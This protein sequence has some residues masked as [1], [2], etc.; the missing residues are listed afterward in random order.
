MLPVA[1]SSYTSSHGSMSC[2]MFPCRE[3]ASISPQDGRTFLHILLFPEPI[4]IAASVHNWEGGFS[5]LSFP[6]LF[7]LSFLSSSAFVFVLAKRIHRA[8]AAL[9]Q[10]KVL[11]GSRPLINLIDSSVW[12]STGF[13]SLYL[14]APLCLSEGASHLSI[15]ARLSQI[16]FVDQIKPFLV[17]CFRTYSSIQLISLVTSS[18]YRVIM[19]LNNRL[20]FR[21]GFIGMQVTFTHPYR[22]TWRLE[23]KLNTENIRG[24][25]YGMGGTDPIW[26]TTPREARTVYRCSKVDGDPRVTE[27]EAVMKVRMQ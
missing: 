15:L 7:S 18:F 3:I 16:D 12:S 19:P 8:Q 4:N 5:L 25:R 24:D 14:S 2:P 17:R 23:E 10:V 21:D 20:Y 9:F 26:P 13:L 22:S 6:S 11:T 27:T 1:C